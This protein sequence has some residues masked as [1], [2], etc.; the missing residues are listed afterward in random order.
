MEKEIINVSEKL[1][2]VIEEMVQKGFSEKDLL[3]A[4]KCL[5]DYIG[6]T[7]AGSRQE[8]YIIEEYI[9]ENRGNYSVIGI[10]DRADL[11]SAAL[12]N[13]Y[14][15]HVL[16]LDDG[17]RMGMM[18]LG[19]PIFS[20]LLSVAEKYNCN[21]HDLL[22]GSIVGYEVA[23][24][25][26]SSMQ[27]NH[28][29]K[30]FHAS[31]TCGTI[32]CAMGIAVMLRYKQKEKKNTLSA[33]AASGAGLL[34]VITG[35]SMQKPYNIS[36]AAVSGINAALFGKKIVGPKDILGGER[37]FIKNLCDEC[38]T[39]ILFK[40]NED[41]YIHTI[42]MK[43]YAA[44]RHC[45]SPIEAALNISNKHK[46][47]ESDIESVIIETYSLAVKGHDHSL[48]ESVNSAKMSIPYSVAV[49]LL[50][51]RAGMDVYDKD[52]INNNE[53]N[54]LAR[55]VYVIEKEEFSKEFPKKR[56]A[57]VIVKWKDKREKV[58]IVQHPKGEPENPMDNKELLDKFTV[59]LESSG[60]SKN[61]TNE[62]VECVMDKK[63]YTV[64]KLM[65][66]LTEI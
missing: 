43:P 42:Y 62:I 25:L 40:D 24:R 49:A 12:V 29:L 28:K 37:G 13:A 4:K 41:A 1:I 17:H 55:K 23:I 19:A 38:K 46:I 58:F 52:M 9:C 66:L 53:I 8:R 15:A 6:V 54:A 63:D 57:K 2:D 34:E 35:E 48:I 45:H 22:N 51:N 36:N 7:L 18:H 50:Y 10:R 27:P 44:C 20:G 31:G 11:N 16:E 39:E 32:G 60:I 33:A 47:I 5:L 3:Q 30:G 21:M 59:L 61:R 56:L 65:K 14:N 26:S 64:N